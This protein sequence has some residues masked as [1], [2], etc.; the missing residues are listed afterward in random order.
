M[1]SFPFVRIFLHL[2]TGR[3]KWCSLSLSSCH[4]IRTNTLDLINNYVS[5]FICLRQHS[6]RTF[7]PFFREIFSNAIFIVS[8][9]SL[10]STFSSSFY[11]C[12]SHRVNFFTCDNVWIRLVFF[13]LTLL[14]SLISVTRRE[15]FRWL[16]MWFFF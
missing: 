8:N 9:T 2:P 5:K 10:R 1:Y 12:T 7:Y 4:R 3:R 11:A 16:K 14:C 15:S 13:N 6:D